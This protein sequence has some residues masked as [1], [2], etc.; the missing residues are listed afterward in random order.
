M[1]LSLR[2]RNLALVEEAAVEWASGLNVV[3]GETGAGKSILIGALQLLLGERADK[4]WIRSGSDYALAE[5][6]FDIRRAPEAAAVLEELGL[7][8]ADDSRLVIRRVVRETSAGQI[9]INDSPVTLQALRRLGDQLVDIHG[10]YDHQSLLDPRFQ[11]ALLDSF[12]GLHEARRECAGAWQRILELETQR[13]ELGGSDEDV[14]ARI[15]LL[16]FRVKE[17]EDA[18]PQA[19]EDEAVAREHA[20]ASQAQR[21]LELGHAALNALQEGEQ[22]AFDALAAAQ[23]ALDEL[24][25][26]MPDGAAWREEARNAARQIQALAESIRASLDR[27]ETDPGRLAWLEQRLAT[28]Q[29]L[30]KKYGVDAAGLVQVLEESRTALRELLRRDERL[31]ELEQRIQQAREAHLAAALA[32][33]ARRRDAASA[34]AAAVTRHLGELGFA[35]ASFSVELAD[36]PPG[37]TGCDEVCFGFA[38]NPGEP[39]KPLR[40][41]ASSGEMARVMLATK[42]ALAQHDKI[43]VL[44]FDEVDANIGGEIGLA[45]GKKLAALGKSH[46]VICITHLPQVAAQGSAHYAVSKTIRNGRTVTRVERLDEEGRIAELARMLGGRDHTRVTIQHAREM[47]AAARGEG[48]RA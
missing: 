18:A 44:I 35:R 29:K 38:P 39:R 34:L 31:E 22:N 7:P 20:I 23:R 46:Q 40:E 37:P 13:R 28:Y 42:A 21:I 26:L 32:L 12:G 25:R 43:P 10:P 15:D 16:R 33:R 5:A 6:V 1:L 27:V 9:L 24:S 4:K 17:L 47:L 11:L 45:V 3:T 14:S 41:I 36:A 2:V 8:P 30:R 19:G 48:R